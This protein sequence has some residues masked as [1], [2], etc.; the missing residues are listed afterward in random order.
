M[1]IR[2]L[3]NIPAITAGDNTILKELLHPD[4]EYNFSG[5]Y[6]IAHAVVPAGKTSLK[7]KL[8]TDEVYFV[9]SGQG[10]MHIDNE[11]AEIEAG[12]TVDIPPGSVQWLENN[13]DTDIIFICIV[14]PAWQ[15]ENEEIID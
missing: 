12:D 11:T 14:D 13:S 1:L 7:H 4:R 9:L 2:K 3:K 5:R 10:I 6:S 15:S 8:T